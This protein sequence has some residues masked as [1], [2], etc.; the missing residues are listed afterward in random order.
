MDGNHAM[1][2]SELDLV[3]LVVADTKAI[4]MTMAWNAGCAETQKV[5]C[6]LATIEVQGPH[7]Y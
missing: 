3:S 4:L 2:E 5:D 6:L 7:I 1:C